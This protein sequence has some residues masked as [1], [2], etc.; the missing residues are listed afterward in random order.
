[1][2]KHTQIIRRLT[3]VKNQGLGTRSKGLKTSI[4]AQ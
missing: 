1:M 2:V 3:A 4:Q